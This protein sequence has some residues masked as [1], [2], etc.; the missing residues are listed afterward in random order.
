LNFKSFFSLHF[1]I[2]CAV[3]APEKH[4]A[5]A[6]ANKNIAIFLIF[7]PPIILLEGFVLIHIKKFW[8]NNYI[9]FLF[10]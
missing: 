2:G 9:K 1:S 10:S 4:T 6:R 8:L 7:S 5:I 3:T